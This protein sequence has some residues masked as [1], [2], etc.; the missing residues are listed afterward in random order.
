MMENDIETSTTRN[1]ARL[2]LDV[3]IKWHRG[4]ENVTD[5]LF[6]HK[7]AILHTGSGNWA[8]ISPISIKKCLWC[9]GTRKLLIAIIERRRNCVLV[10]DWKTSQLWGRCREP[11]PRWTK[12]KRYKECDDCESNP[13]LR[14]PT[15]IEVN[16]SK[17]VFQS[18]RAIK[19]W[20]KMW[21]MKMQLFLINRIAYVW[22]ETTSLQDLVAKCKRR[23]WN[24]RNCS[25]LAQGGMASRH[26]SSEIELVQRYVI[27]MRMWNVLKLLL[28]ILCMKLHFNMWFFFLFDHAGHCQ[29]FVLPIYPG[30]SRAH[31]ERPDVSQP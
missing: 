28:Q 16:I 19:D 11:F 5:S 6:N 18:G 4:I 23:W 22:G 15:R 14:L 24:G 2:R 13:I 30:S 25:T 27:L 8:P 1:Y 7:P 12:S 20:R 21:A 17:R 29:R 10:D 3:Q 9:P 31:V 26:T